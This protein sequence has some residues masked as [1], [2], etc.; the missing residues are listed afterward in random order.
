MPNIIGLL[1]DTHH[2]EISLSNYGI[3][4][5]LRVTKYRRP[6]VYDIQSCDAMLLN[7]AVT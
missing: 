6:F 4:E 3:D 5:K 7:L 1:R 2:V